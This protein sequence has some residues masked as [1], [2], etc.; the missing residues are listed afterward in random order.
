MISLNDA[1][2]LA[3]HIYGEQKDNDGEP[4]IFH[5]IH[6][7]LG[8]YTEKERI[9][10]ILHD[11][12]E[13]T[14][15]TSIY[16]QLNDLELEDGLRAITRLDTETYNEYILRL[17]GNQLARRVKITDLNHNL[18]RGQ[19]KPRYETLRPRYLKALG[20][21]NY[22]ESEEYPEGTWMR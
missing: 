14:K 7:M 17:S 3:L 20:T 6:V 1:I 12:V 2:K 19:G 10:A 21:L 16:T 8:V 4:L 22:E 15:D 18:K 5:S 13:Y 11:T 9:L